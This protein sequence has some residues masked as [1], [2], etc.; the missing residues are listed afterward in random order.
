MKPNILIISTAP[1]GK[2]GVSSVVEMQMQALCDRCN[3]HHISSQKKGAKLLKLIMMF[4]GVFT[5]PWIIVY[6]KIDIVHIHGSMSSSFLRKSIF[7]LISKLMG[8]KVIHHMHSAKVNEY[9]SSRSKLK[10]Q[11][12]CFLMDQYD[13]VIVLND[14]WKSVLQKKTRTDIFPVFNAIEK[15]PLPC[16]KKSGKFTIFII[17]EVGHRKGTYDVLKVAKKLSTH[18]DIEF[19]IAGGGT[20]FEKLKQQCLT[21]GLDNIITWL[22][23]IG[24]VERDQEMAN[25]DIFFLPSYHEGMPMAILEGMCAELPVISTPVGGIPDCV[26]D[27]QTGYLHEPG[28][29][30]GFADSILKLKDNPDILASMAKASSER[31]AT[32]FSPKQFA[33]NVM[34]VYRKVLET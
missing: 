7:M 32:V 8:K 3:I 12:V 10:G 28:D 20:D 13:V 9:F 14:Y 31:A 26:I 23:W 11:L 21:E 17:G 15:R 18:E 6:K 16:S 27:G 19:R 5:L 1:G 33:E 24:P 4:R 30:D 22:G 2:G 29:I 25:A 34:T